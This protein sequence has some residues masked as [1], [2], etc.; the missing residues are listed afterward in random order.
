MGAEENYN[1]GQHNCDYSRGRGACT[2]TCASTCTKADTGVYTA[3][4]FN[5]ADAGCS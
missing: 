4:T 3:G 5:S 2:E 1:T